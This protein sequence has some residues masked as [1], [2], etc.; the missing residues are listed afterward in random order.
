MCACVISTNN[1][2]CI[3]CEGEAIKIYYKIKEKKDFK[4][5]IIFKFKFESCKQKKLFKLSFKKVL[6]TNK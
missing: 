4:D 1:T 3:F 5:N 6:K 2:G